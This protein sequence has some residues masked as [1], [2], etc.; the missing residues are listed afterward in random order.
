MSYRKV[1]IGKEVWEYSAGR[2]FGAKIRSPTG[3][4][5]WVSIADLCGKTAEQIERE[6]REFADFDCE[7]NWQDPLSP[8]LVK[9]YI[10]RH[11]VK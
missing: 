2:G 3:K 10:E 6:N 4:V 7:T 11:L 5:S 1:H 9:G 8:G